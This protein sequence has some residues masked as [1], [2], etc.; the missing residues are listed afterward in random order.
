MSEILK[1]HSFWDGGSNSF[2]GAWAKVGASQD[3]DPMS[4]AA[5]EG[6]FLQNFLDTDGSKGPVVRALSTFNVK[7]IIVS[8]NINCTTT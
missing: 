2:L 5:C 1:R 8:M 7:I 6:S 3:D 4:S